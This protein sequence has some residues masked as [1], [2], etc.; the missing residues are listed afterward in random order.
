M[1]KF[2]SKEYVQK[3]LACTFLDSIHRGKMEQIILAYVLPKETVPAIMMFDRN[4]KV[5]VHLPDGDTN[6]L[7]TVAWMLPGYTFVSYLFI[8]SL[9]YILQTAIDMT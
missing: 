9:D 5:K 7:N 3:N 4:T 8:I 2:E 1:N 6:F